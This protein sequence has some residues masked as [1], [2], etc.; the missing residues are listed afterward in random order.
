MATSLLIVEEEGVQTF[1][2]KIYTEKYRHM[3][4]EGDET[5]SKGRRATS[6]RCR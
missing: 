5:D 4:R 6:H 1:T 3:E 2:A